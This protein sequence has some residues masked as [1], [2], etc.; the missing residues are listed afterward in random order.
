MMLIARDDIEQF[1]P[2]LNPN[3][4]YVRAAEQLK[5]FILTKLIN[6]EY[7]AYQCRTFSLLQERTRCSYLKHLCEHLVEKTY[8][9]LCDEHKRS[10]QRRL[11]LLNRKRYLPSMK[12][13]FTRSQTLPDGN[14]QS[15]KSDQI[16]TTK[17]KKLVRSD[18]SIDIDD[19]Q[20]SSTKIAAFE[21]VKHMCRCYCRSMN[22][23]CLRH[24]D[25]RSD[26]STDKHR[27]SVDHP[28]S[29]STVN[30]Y[31][32]DESDEGLVSITFDDCPHYCF[33]LLG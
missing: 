9:N 20:M 24:R 19:S 1:P 16:K 12:K 15:I 23:Y 5:G 14:R 29:S 21:Y 13:I 4:V 28:Y 31:G 7:A 22:N 10:G 27:D 30:V 26:D 6:A 3:V 33:Q 18:K 32:G 25:V 17:S 11:S 2:F 8:E